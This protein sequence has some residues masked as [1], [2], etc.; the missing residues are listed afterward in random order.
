MIILRGMN[1]FG[2]LTYLQSKKRVEDVFMISRFYFLIEQ[3][4]FMHFCV[5]RPT[6]RTARLTRLTP[7]FRPLFFL[8][9][10]VYFAL[11]F[12]PFAHLLAAAL[13]AALHFALPLIC[14]PLS[15]L[16]IQAWNLPIFNH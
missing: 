14:L 9:L 16:F 1:L 4:T 3:Q 11:T 7:F 13:N 5:F 8:Y 10:R 15:D 6:L 12:A 2:H